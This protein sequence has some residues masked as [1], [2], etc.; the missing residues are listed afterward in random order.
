MNLLMC[1][2]LEG[3]ERYLGDNK[4]NAV[5]T[6]KLSITYVKQPFVQLTAIPARL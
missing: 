1:D 2:A 5:V 3:R 4:E 6:L